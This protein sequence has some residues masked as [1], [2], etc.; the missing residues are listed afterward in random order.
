MKNIF[1]S[2]KLTLVREKDNQYEVDNVINNPMDIETIARNVLEIDKNAEEVV[3]ILALNIKNKVE[4]T[5]EVSRGTVNASL[6]SPR[7]IFK[8]LL[9][10]NV[11]KFITIHNHP[12]GNTEAS[13]NDIQLCK[14]LNE[15]GVIMNI[16]QVDFCIIGK[17]INSFKENGLY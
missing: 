10:L 2:Y 16:K 8:R 13:Y 12:S 9:L 14:C 3:C 7:D 15:C 17:D 11:P 4:A 1:P 6:I 5:F